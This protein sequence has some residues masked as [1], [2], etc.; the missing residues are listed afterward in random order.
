MFPN[1]TLHFRQQT[2]YLQRGNAE[3]MKPPAFR[4]QAIM[5]HIDQTPQQKAEMVLMS[6]GKGPAFEWIM[7][8][9]L[10]PRLAFSL[11]STLQNV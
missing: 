6:T 2:S 9:F 8:D 7:F 10:I 4:Q 5:M 3:H 11:V 1:A